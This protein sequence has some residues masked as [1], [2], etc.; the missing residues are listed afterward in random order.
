MKKR[1]SK[2]RHIKKITLYWKEKWESF[3]AEKNRL[4]ERMDKNIIKFDMLNLVPD[5]TVDTSTPDIDTPELG[6]RHL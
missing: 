1:V 3:E 5:D 6:I 2:V 4:Y